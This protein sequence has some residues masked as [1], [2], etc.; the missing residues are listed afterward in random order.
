M[1][2]EGSCSILFRKAGAHV[3]EARAKLAQFTFR[4][5]QVSLQLKSSVQ[6]DHH[7]K[8]EVKAQVEDKHDQKVV[9]RL[10]QQQQIL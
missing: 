6:G 1:R 10:I 4:S 3:P 2:R 8:A 7:R 9:A 5:I